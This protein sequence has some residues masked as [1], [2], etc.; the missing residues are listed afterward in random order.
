MLLKYHQFPCELGIFAYDQPKNEKE[1]NKIHFLLVLRYYW[2]SSCKIQALWYELYLTWPLNILYKLKLYKTV[3]FKFTTQ[4]MKL[5]RCYL[6]I[7][8]FEET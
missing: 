3:Q 6:F 8:F 4:R 7:P 1:L 2:K 5:K